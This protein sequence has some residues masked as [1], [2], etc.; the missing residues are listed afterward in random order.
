MSTEEIRRKI[1]NLS[2]D[3][4]NAVDEY[5]TYGIYKHPSDY[6]KNSFDDF[7]SPR[8]KDGKLNSNDLD[9]IFSSKI[10]ILLQDWA[11]CDKLDEIVN[12]PKKREEKEFILEH[13]YSPNDFRKTNEKLNESIKKFPLEL[14][15]S[16]KEEK[17]YYITNI[18]PYLKPKV[19][20]DIHQPD[21]DRAFKKF[22]W[23]EVKVIRP[24]VVICLG[25]R[26]YPTFLKNCLTLIKNKEIESL[27][28]KES[29]TIPSFVLKLPKEEIFVYSLYHPAAWTGKRKFEDEWKELKKLLANPD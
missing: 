10:M 17:S 11:S 3:C 12:D 1:R 26:V 24:K 4:R 21:M 9:K 20:S 14:I 28:S 29:N 18:F 2:K 13:G 27:I 25:K 19:D 22:C 23:E 15:G 5:Q 7:V 6:F 8:T 16:E